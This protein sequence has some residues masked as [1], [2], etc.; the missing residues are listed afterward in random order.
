[1][2]EPTCDACGCP[3]YGDEYDGGSIGSHLHFNDDAC[4]DA[5]KARIV[6]LEHPTPCR[7]TY[8]EAEDR[9]NGTCGKRWHFDDG[10]PAEN[11]MRYCPDCGHPLA[12]VEETSDE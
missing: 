4:F 3:I 7:W 8:N 2:G 12:L 9:W 5:L 10:G 6:E 11:R 1:M